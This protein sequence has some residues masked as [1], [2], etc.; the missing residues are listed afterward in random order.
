MRRR[1][2]SKLFPVLL[3]CLYHH[4]S[5]HGAAASA[6]GRLHAGAPQINSANVIIETSPGYDHSASDPGWRAPRAMTVDRDVPYSDY[7]ALGSNGTD[8]CSNLWRASYIVSACSKSQSADQLV[9]HLRHHPIN[10]RTILSHFKSEFDAIK[11]KT[12]HEV[13]S[14]EVLQGEYTCLNRTWTEGRHTCQCGCDKVVRLHFALEV[15]I[16]VDMEKI[17]AYVRN[18]ILSHLNFIPGVCASQRD[19][20]Q[21][22]STDHSMA[23]ARSGAVPS[24]RFG[25]PQGVAATFRRVLA[26]PGSQAPVVA[27]SQCRHGDWRTSFD[28]RGWSTCPPSALFI[29]GLYRSQW[30]Q[31]PVSEAIAMLDRVQCCEAPLSYKDMPTAFQS[32]DWSDTFKSEG[33]SVCPSGFF[34]HGMYRA[35]YVSK[36]DL[37]DIEAGKCA[38]PAN[39]PLRHGDCYDEDI[40]EAFDSAG[41][42]SCSKGGY[43]VAGLYRGSQGRLRDIDRLRCCSM[44]E[45]QGDQPDLVQELPSGSITASSCYSDFSSDGMHPVLGKRCEVRGYQS[46]CLK[47]KK[48]AECVAEALILGDTRPVYQPTPD[49]GPYIV[50]DLGLVRHVEQGVIFGRGDRAP[51]QKVT[52]YRIFVKRELDAGWESVGGVRE[53]GFQDFA[54]ADKHKGAPFELGREARYV[55]VQ[56]VRCNKQCALRLQLFGRGD[57][58]D[59]SAGD[60]GIGGEIGAEG[61]VGLYGASPDANPTSLEMW[62]CPH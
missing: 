61:D 33:W 13:V 16:H 29:N 49:D 5:L 15:P 3:V 55:K 28:S 1:G 62:T 6:L 58:Q 19:T 32:V 27:S 40:S 17:G 37:T 14:Y 21:G 46:Q 57:W 11:P 42:A 44:I 18:T 31:G 52:H 26:V 22:A 8:G 60:D 23:A 7:S 45:E 9:F 35:S 43:Y 12:D 47:F 39:H 56:A 51:Y 53:T 24:V 20:Y 59:G 36:A 30:G 38:K 25:S 41:W 48:L 54:H 50:V 4:V 10:G 2:A 34:L